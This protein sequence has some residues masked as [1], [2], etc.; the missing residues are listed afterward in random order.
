M[1]VLTGYASVAENAI[2]ASLAAFETVRQASV[3]EPG[4]IRYDYWQNVRHPSQF[5]FVEEWESPAALKTHFE[6]D[7]FKTFFATV[8]PLLTAEPEI[9]IFAATPI[10]L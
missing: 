1:V 7:A 3:L 5:V 8:G 2:D 6:Q 9:R 10:E 4:C